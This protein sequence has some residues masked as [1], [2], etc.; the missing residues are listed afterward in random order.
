MAA[1]QRRVTSID[2]AREAGVSTTTVSYVLNRTANQK[3]SEE[4]RRKVLA[5]VE[6]LGYTPSAPARDL[7]RGRSDVVLLLLKDL[8][9]GYT[10]IELVERLT[11]ALARHGL[12]LLTRLERNR[13]L[14]ELWRELTPSAVVFFT[15][16]TD[17]DRAQL[18]AEGAHVVYSWLDSSGDDRMSLGQ[19]EIGRLQVQHLL[20]SGHRRLGYLT[21]D[22][23]RLGDFVRPRL[24]GVRRACAEN[25]LK[26]P[27][28][29]RLP[30]GSAEAVRIARAWH[31][32]GITGVCAFNDEYAFS[33]LSGMNAAGLRVPEDLAVIGVDDIPLAQFAFPP[34]TT[35][36]QDMRIVADNLT[37]QILKGLNLAV[38]RAARISPV[39]LVVRDSA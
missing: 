13:P 5:A 38:G 28:V 35:I 21:P 29:R 25:R 39:T 3:I 22:D 17:E 14:A 16:V 31:D 26:P 30:F 11:D 10:A 23:D 33:F 4:T 24:E 1:R 7:R 32:V 18:G 27:D 37:H 15:T 8:P 12:T 19:A 6:K 2:V 36:R 20:A 9:L 34:L